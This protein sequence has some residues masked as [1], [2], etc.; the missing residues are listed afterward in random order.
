L[1]GRESNGL[2]L[3]AGVAFA[4]STVPLI[5]ANARRVGFDLGVDPRLMLSLQEVGMLDDL[6]ARVDVPTET[7]VMLVD[8][9]APLGGEVG[10]MGSS[11]VAIRGDRRGTLGPCLGNGLARRSDPAMFLTAGHVAGPVGSSMVTINPRPALL[12]DRL[13]PLGTVVFRQ[14]PEPHGP[15][16][17]DMALIETMRDAEPPCQVAS[18]SPL[19]SI[20]IPTTIR[21]GVSGRGHGLVLGALRTYSDEEGRMNWKNSWLMFPGSLGTEGD[22]GSAVEM[23]DGSILGILVGGSRVVGRQSFG[24]L[25]IQDLEAAIVDL[26]M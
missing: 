19:Q 14:V 24:A 10:R 2:V 4:E 18:L 13:R 23:L 12:P 7:R 26:F 25:Y 6:L 20:P 5:L 9:P 21:G 15:P 3:G 17:Y 8:P 1:V 16:E 11:G 22:S